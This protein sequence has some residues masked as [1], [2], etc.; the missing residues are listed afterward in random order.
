ML[1]NWWFAA[2]LSIVCASMGQVLLKLGVRN[3][4]PADAL[5]HPALL[6]GAIVHPYVLAGIAAFFAS[7]LFWLVAINGRQ[8]SAVY[9]LASLAYV[10]VTIASVVVFRDTVTIQKVLGIALIILGIVVLNAGGALT[11]VGER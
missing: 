10:L 4:L 5:R 2:L 6:L 8:L 1:S 11:T 3:A 9:P 7:M